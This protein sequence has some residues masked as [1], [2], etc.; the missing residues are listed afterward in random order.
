M[1]YSLPGLEHWTEK[2]PDPLKI[3]KYRQP[4]II[5]PIGTCFN[6]A[7]KLYRKCEGC[8]FTEVARCERNGYVV[9]RTVRRD[10]NK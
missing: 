4:E 5:Y 3:R 8:Q 7:A 6:P 2:K 1:T 9:D 10:V